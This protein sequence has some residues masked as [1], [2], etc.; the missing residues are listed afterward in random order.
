MKTLTIISHTEHYLKPDGTVVG[1]SSTVTEINHLL[2]E[3]DVIYH[4]AMLYDVE[5][6]PNTM[7]YGSD[8]II[9]KPIPAV[10]GPSFSEKFKIIL[11]IPRTINI[12]RKT[13]QSSDFFQFRAPTG[14]GVFVIPYLV[15]FTSKTG[16]FK[17][18]GDWKGKQIPWAFKLQRW[19]LTNQ[20]RIVTINGRWKDQKRHC[21]TFENPCLTDSEIEIGRQVCKLKEYNKKLQ[22][23]FVGRLEEAKGLGLLI[24]ALSQLPSNLKNQIDTIH[25]VG[26][27][28]A[29]S[30][31]EHMTISSHLHFKFHGFLS[32]T[33]VH[34]IYKLSHAIIL[35]SK[36]EGFPKVIAEAM[37]YGCIP[38][39]SNISSIN[40]YVKN[41]QNGYLLDDIS[42]K[43]IQNE[44]IKILKLDQ[45]Q[46]RKMI[47]NNESM[48][49]QFTYSYYNHRI[50]NEVL[51]IGQSK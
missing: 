36:T 7:P 6:P 15:F 3:F 46:F 17:Y 40:N 21:M 24:Q 42:E 14:I 45:D 50:V 35:P 27:G 18:A 16:W 4:L 11:T 39:V 10:G 12:I 1:L 22:L 23:C 33:D 43:A 25:I 2:D 41:K 48:V 49:Q 34:A 5:A 47:V 44:V 30:V 37:N 28:S 13:L 38:I 8:K 31:Y 29:R 19:Y 26:D 32:R 20:K 9:F 51:K